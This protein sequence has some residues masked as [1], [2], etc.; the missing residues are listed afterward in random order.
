MG[1]YEILF[2]N[3]LLVLFPAIAIALFTGE[4]QTAYYYEQWFDPV[5]IINFGLSSIMGFVLMYSQILCTQLTSA[6][7]MVVVG[8]I[9]NIIVTYIGMFIG[10][11]Y[12]FAVMNFIGI[13]I[14]VAASL[15]YS[16]LKYRESSKRQSSPPT[17]A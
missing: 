15:V 3:A 17:N 10:G 1:S 16:L 13:N 5:F 11:D 14:S 12:V 2:Y 4:L 9:K 6:L 8:C 7:T